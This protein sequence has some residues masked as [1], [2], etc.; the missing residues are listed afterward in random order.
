MSKSSA[1]NPFIFPAVCA[2]GVFLIR[3]LPWPEKSERALST[4]GDAAN[5]NQR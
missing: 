2:W 5:D 3:R 4:S 1:R